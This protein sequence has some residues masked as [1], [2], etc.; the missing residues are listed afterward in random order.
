MQQTNEQPIEPIQSSKNIWITAI[1][2]I[3]TAIVVSSGIYAW[4]KNEVNKLNNQ[5][6]QAQKITNDQ[7]EQIV[8]LKDEIAQLKNQLSEASNYKTSE[9]IGA[10]HAVNINTIT[11]TNSVTNMNSSTV[12]W[13]TYTNTTYHFSIQYPNTWSVVEDDTS[14]PFHVTISGADW[15]MTGFI[16]IL[17]RFPFSTNGPAGAEN[18][19]FTRTSKATV[20]GGKSARE[21]LWTKKENNLAYSMNIIFDELPYD[22]PND[23]IE[24]QP[25]EERYISISAPENGDLALLRQ[26]LS[27]FQF[28]D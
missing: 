7:A 25:N 3:I 9:E 5:I 26:I 21:Y 20:V 10:G 28:A 4:Q 13:K 18:D 22:W 1:A 24:N 23:H 16:T 14:A 2:V 19:T 12:G 17:N 11:N 27:T 6:T 15:R 8:S